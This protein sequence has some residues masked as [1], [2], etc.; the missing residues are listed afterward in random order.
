MLRPRCWLY[1]TPT[2]ASVYG[3]SEIR[4]RSGLLQNVGVESAVSA[5]W[6][7]PSMDASCTT[8]QGEYG[9]SVFT[10]HTLILDRKGN[11]WDVQNTVPT[12]CPI[13]A[14]N[15]VVGMAFCGPRAMF[16]ILRDHNILQ[17]Y[18]LDKDPS[19]PPSMIAEQKHPPVSAILPVSMEDRNAVSTLYPA[20]PSRLS[21]ASVTSEAMSE[22][23][24]MKGWQSDGEESEEDGTSRIFRRST[25]T[26]RPSSEDSSISTCANVPKSFLPGMH[27][28]LSTLSTVEPQKDTVADL[29][30]G[31]RR[32]MIRT[33][34]PF[35]VPPQAAA[36][37]PQFRTQVLAIVF[38]WEYSVEDL[39]NDESAQAAPGDPR[40]EFLTKWLNNTAPDADMHNKIQDAKKCAEECMQ[41][42][43][44]HGAVCTLLQVRLYDQAVGLYKNSGRY[45]EAVLVAF[46]YV[47]RWEYQ[48]SLL[49]AWACAEEHSS[50]QL[51]RR[52]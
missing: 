50:P 20:Q 24:I 3:I 43:N 10:Y 33:R 21:V 37:L 40:R 45:M 17:K 39:V 22:I 44:V 32:R 19:K 26:T 11:V 18:A 23:T 38:G 35:P 52:W 42:G 7:G 9:S 15:D 25:S 14:P 6:A 51:A 16:F 31:A 13:A 46:L 12:S 28:L 4:R 8:K 34:Y 47:P 48:I 27:D 2:V 1:K 49:G 30:P 29:F 41:S 5:G 36:S